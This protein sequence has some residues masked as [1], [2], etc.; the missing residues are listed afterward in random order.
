MD[1]LR[2]LDSGAMF[3]QGHNQQRKFENSVS[4]EARVFSDQ[5]GIKFIKNLINHLTNINIWF[6]FSYEMNLL[7]KSQ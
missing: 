1:P 7:G 4:N 2:S 3:C 5:Q 6:I